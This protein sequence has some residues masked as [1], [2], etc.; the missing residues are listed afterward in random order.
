MVLFAV[1]LKGYFYKKMNNVDLFSRARSKIGISR[2][3]DLTP[4]GKDISYQWRIQQHPP[5]LLFHGLITGV[6]GM[7]TCQVA[8]LRLQKSYSFVSNLM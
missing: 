3:V 6:Y 4:D 8:R 7:V 5:R 2:L 1:I